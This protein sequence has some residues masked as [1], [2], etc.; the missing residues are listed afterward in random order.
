MNYEKSEW[1]KKNVDEEKLRAKLAEEGV[2]ASLKE[3]NNMPD[4][5]ATYNDAKAMVDFL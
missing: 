3:E 1:I 5:P 4:L 2:L